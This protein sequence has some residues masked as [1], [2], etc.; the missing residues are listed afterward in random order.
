MQANRPFMNALQEL[1]LLESFVLDVE[2]ND[3][4]QHRLIGFY[5]I[6]EDKLAAL[7]EAT[8]AR[9][10]KNGYLQ[11]IYMTVASLSQFRELIARKNRKV[12]DAGRTE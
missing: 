1:N 3:G 6:N 8:V 2:L 7:D 9:L 10:H 12:S 5:T 4:S 11:A